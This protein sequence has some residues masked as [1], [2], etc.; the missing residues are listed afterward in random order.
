MSSEDCI[1]CKVVDG[2]IPSDKV[3]EDGKCVAFNDISPQAP[4]HILIVPRQ[5]IESLDKAGVSDR[6]PSD[7]CF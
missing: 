1:F 3:F 2:S 5:H 4:T 7:I 6:K